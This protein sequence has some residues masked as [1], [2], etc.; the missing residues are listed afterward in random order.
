FNNLL[1]VINGYADLML[2]ALEDDHPMSEGIKQIRNAGAKG[3][4]LTRQLLAFGRKQV[5]QPQLCDL[6]SLIVEMQPMHGRVIAENIQFLVSLESS[7]GVIRAD[8][9]QIHQ[10]LMNLAVNGQ[11][12]MPSGGNLTIQTRN[13][14]V[15]LET[16]DQPGELGAKPFVLLQ[17]RDTGVGMD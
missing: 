13:V 7:L 15:G 2:L 1:T 9:S 14:W 17:I 8:R 3:A 6:N 11:E 10:V 12:A 4:E 5:S 16:R